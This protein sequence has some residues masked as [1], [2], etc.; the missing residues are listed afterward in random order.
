MPKRPLGKTGMEVSVL[1]FGASPL[2]GIFRVSTNTQAAFEACFRFLLSRKV[3]DPHECC[4]ACSV[5]VAR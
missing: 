1:G 5:V 4:W 2:G 3:C